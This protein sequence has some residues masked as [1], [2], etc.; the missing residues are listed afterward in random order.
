MPAEI[1]LIVAHTS[2]SFDDVGKLNLPQFRALQ[3]AIIEKAK[4]AN[5]FFIGDGQK[6]P[7]PG[8]KVALSQEQFA[9]LVDRR[10]K[11]LGK[12]VLSLDEVF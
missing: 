9:E 2:L 3:T 12:D 6:S 7:K 11:E 4:M 1:A 5:P 10:K 8:D